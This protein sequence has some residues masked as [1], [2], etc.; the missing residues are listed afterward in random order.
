MGKDKKKPKI[1]YTDYFM[2]CHFGICNG[3]IDNLVRIKIKD[4]IAW[5]GVALPNDLIDINQPELFGGNEKEGGVVGKVQFLA[6]G[7]TQT[8]P[9]PLA[10]RQGFHPD[11]AV[12]YRHIASA[13]FYGNGATGGA[14]SSNQ[15]GGLF[16]DELWQ[17]V[18]PDTDLPAATP[19]AWLED[20]LGV[21]NSTGGQT[22]Y[23]GGGFLWSQNNP[24]MP[25]AALTITR[26]PK[27]SLN[28]ALASIQW[29][30]TLRV[31][32]H[33]S[34]YDEDAADDGK[35][36][37]DKQPGP[38]ANP[39]HMIYECMTNVAWGAG[40]PDSLINLDSFNTA[41]QTLYDEGFGLSMLWT[42]QAE[43]EKFIA[44]ICD[45][46][47]GA[48]YVDP[49]TGLFNLKLFRDDYDPNNLRVV[50]ESNCRFTK[51]GRKG[52]GEVINEINVSWTN[53][54]TEETETITFHDQGQIAAQQ[55]AI[56]SDPRDYYG[57]RNPELATKVGLRDIR[58]ASFPLFTT[59]CQG[60][61]SFW[62]LVPG[63]VVR[64][65]IAEDG[66]AGM[67]CRVIEIDRGKP[68][69]SVIKF[70]V[71][72]EVFSHK[73]A[74]Y[75]TPLQTMWTSPNRPPSDL[76]FFRSFTV[77][78]AFLAANGV[79]PTNDDYPLTAIGF[80]GAHYPN[81]DVRN[82]E[83][84][85]D[86]VQPNGSTVLT[87]IGTFKQTGRS[88]LPTGLAFEA[89]SVITGFGP[90]F[91]NVAYPSAAD[92]VLIVDP[93]DVDGG[94]EFAMI[95]SFDEMAGTIT[96][97]RGV[98]DTVPKAWS[99]D[100]EIWFLN[101]DFTA[102]DP[103][104]RAALSEADYKI[105]TRSSMGLQSLAAGNDFTHTPNEREYEPMRPADVKVAG[106][107][108]FRTTR[109]EYNDPADPTNLTVT[110]ANRNRLTE[111]ALVTRWTDANVTPEVGQTT[112]IRA[113]DAVGATVGEVTGLT[114]T[115]GVIPI[116]Y[117]FVGPVDI[118]VIAVRD[119]YESSINGFVPIDVIRPGG[120]DKVYGYDY[121]GTTGT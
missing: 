70:K 2:S 117:A 115:S 57:I 104:E 55:G 84:W 36:Y 31:E 76:P 13:F 47:Q 87:R 88:S 73:T 7:A 52:L 18:D 118:Y 35:Q 83:I 25:A 54:F 85:S 98:L 69:D 16:F 95:D 32:K 1:P 119:G 79:A 75:Y 121:G 8:L 63:E 27:G 103:T 111:D 19:P 45:H 50:D 22:A 78:Y 43:I 5:E 23:E 15:L 37:E 4:E 29:A 10:L 20:W 99:A 44:E 59:E 81:S 68:G 60:D 93:T 33:K 112:T 100:A 107:D 97:A 108:I 17:T 21:E 66:I 102:V 120:Y 41:A 64:V 86:Q 30:G 94:S 34:Q 92:L 6:G 62:D 74:T 28:P 9:A 109:I 56:V 53:P 114:G 48:V 40:H 14:T 113:V 101:Y 42:G 71:V 61:R 39:S 90:L 67:I 80:L 116:T 51:K 106:Y 105:R 58:S 11:H 110:W 91:G 72:E 26:I 46:I 24:Y 96:L 65:D 49:R 3:P 12:G 89:Q 38:D 82:F 77:P